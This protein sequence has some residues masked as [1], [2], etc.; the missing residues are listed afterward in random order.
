MARLVFKGIMQEVIVDDRFPC[1]Y[2]NN[3][4]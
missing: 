3:Q 4:L 1:N 2:N